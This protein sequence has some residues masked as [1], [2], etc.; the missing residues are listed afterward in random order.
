MAA[1]DTAAYHRLSAHVLELS[2][3][4]DNVFFGIMINTGCAHA[5]SGGVG[6]YRAYCRHI[7]EMEN[8]DKLDVGKCKFGVALPISIGTA[9]IIFPIKHIALRIRMHTVEADVPLLLS[10]VDMDGL[11]PS[12]NNLANVLHHKPARAFTSIVRR[13]GY[14][15]IQRNAKLNSVFTQIELRRLHK[16]FGHPNAHKLYNLLKRAELPDVDE[17]TQ[18]IL[19]KITRHCE[20]CHTYAQAACRFNFLLRDE[21]DLNS[22]MFVDIF[23]VSAKLIIHVVDEATR[24]LAASWLPSVSTE[25]VWKSTRLFWIDIYIGLPDMVTHDAGKHFMANVFQS[26]AGLIKIETKSVRIEA[27][28][29]TSFVE[30]YHT[31]V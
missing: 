21:N 15:F 27:P 24:Y 5:S 20:A 8:I 13:H 14:P 10:L 31:P 28:N 25:S 9:T 26:N 12:Y 23:Y 17:Y 29:A 30:G 2:K 22:S 7:R 19:Q 4:S 16:L 6:Q 11:R 1:T 3:Y 18:K